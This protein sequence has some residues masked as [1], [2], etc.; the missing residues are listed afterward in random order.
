MLFPVRCGGCGKND[1]RLCRECLDALGCAVDPQGMWLP[2]AELDHERDAPL[3]DDER[4]AP[5]RV[6]TAMPY[7]PVLQH[8]LDAFKE[9]GRA[10]L[11][12][13]LAE[14]LRF[15]LRRVGELLPQ[16]DGDRTE[17]IL[18]VPVPSR[19]AARA[20]RG[21]DHIQ[22]LLERAVPNAR[23]VDALRHARAVADQ[24]TLGRDAR[25]SNLHGALVA[26]DLVRGHRCVIVDDLVTTGAT[27]AEAARALEAAHANVLG[28]VAIARVELKY[29]TH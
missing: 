2:G 9:R 18:L 22:L 3:R 16:R 10:D 8:V 5:L 26:H 1:T 19:R 11:A 7:E 23:P 20:R 17:P 15:S 28:A 25:A 24:S 12:K 13:E 14:L 21:Y 29:H 4:V 6:I 27:L